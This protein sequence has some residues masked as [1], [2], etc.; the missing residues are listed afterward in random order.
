MSIPDFPNSTPKGVANFQAI[1]DELL[2]SEGATISSTT[3]EP[4][5]KSNGYQVALKGHET[6][7]EATVESIENYIDNHRLIAEN[8]GADFGLWLNAESGLIEADICIWLDEWDAAILRG[9]SE[10]QKAIWDWQNM[11]P[12]W[13]EY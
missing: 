10:E 12:I 7:I 8:Q 9:R 6:N 5:S 4:I 11:V 3:L 1:L 2:K 13:I